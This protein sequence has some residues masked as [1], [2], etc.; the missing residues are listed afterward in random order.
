MAIVY[1]NI[2]SLISIFVKKA[3]EA[4]KP[5]SN[6][7][8]INIEEY[9][10]DPLVNVDS[11]TKDIYNKTFNIDTLISLDE[12]SKIKYYIENLL[13]PKDFSLDVLRKLPDIS[14]G[15]YLNH[16]LTPVS[17]GKNDG[18]GSGRIVYDLGDKVLKFAFNQSGMYQNTMESRIASRSPYFADVYDVGPKNQWIISEKVIPL[19][20]GEFSVITGIPEALTVGNAG[21]ISKMTA[22]IFNE[23][24]I[25]YELE[26][27]AQQFLKDIYKIHKDFGTIV[28]D[29]INPEHWGKASDGSLKLYDYG[30]D[31]SGY[32]ELYDEL[33]LT[34]EGPTEEEENQLLEFLNK[35]KELSQEHK[36]LGVLQLASFYER[37]IK[38]GL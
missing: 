16:M 4:T 12:Y 21:K 35:N 17:G 19:E 33:G 2:I 26:D 11:Y 6:I 32:S 36:N 34:K 14:I 3:E 10:L 9:S 31:K 18:M 8:P 30:L 20:S 38:I 37:I 23:L 22:Q 24:V 15:I 1:G 29:T 27:D 5:I 13:E 28:G 7:Q 25:R